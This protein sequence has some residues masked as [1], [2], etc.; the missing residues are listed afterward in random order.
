MDAALANLAKPVPQPFNESTPC[1]FL[2]YA[3]PQAALAVN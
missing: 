3:G 2:A 1:P